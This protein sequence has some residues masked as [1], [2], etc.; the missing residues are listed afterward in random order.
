MGI[1]VNFF[2]ITLL[3]RSYSF[4]LLFRKFFKDHL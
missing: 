3:T 2:S 4:P 1:R